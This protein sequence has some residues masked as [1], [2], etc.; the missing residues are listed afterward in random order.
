MD[1]SA[2][3]LTLNFP[4]LIHAARVITYST[5]LCLLEGIRYLIGRILAVV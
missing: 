1:Y 3:Y 2:R 5:P 4:C